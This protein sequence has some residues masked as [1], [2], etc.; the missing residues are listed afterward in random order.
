ME[1]RWPHM[2]CQSMQGLNVLYNQT[3]RAI[4]WQRL[5]SD[6][7]RVVE[8]PATGRARPGLEA[9]WDVVTSYRLTIAIKGKDWPTAQRLQR[10]VIA[11][12]REQAAGLLD[13]P[14]ETLDFEQYT[15][16]RNLGSA[17][18]ALGDLLREQRDPGC[19]APYLEA[20]ALNARIGARREEEMAAHNLGRAYA[21]I[22]QL[23]DLEEAQR[24]YQ[25]ALELLDDGDTLGHARL[26]GQLGN[27]AG[28]RF[29][30][31]QKAKAA[32]QQLLAHANAAIRA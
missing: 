25:R 13:R 7:V 11:G 32:D 5:V 28:T 16:V 26:K 27:L 8:D 21:D 22:E 9:D 19:V 14:P 3:G 1:H 4:E 6:V 12:R 18:H 20:T 31:G 23:R 17:I 24:W 15:R 30:E 2:I 10:A 29:R